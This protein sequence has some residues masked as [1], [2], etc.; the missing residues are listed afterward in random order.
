MIIII[1][2][3]ADTGL[4]KLQIFAYKE[5]PGKSG[6]LG[7]PQKANTNCQVM[8]TTRFHGSTTNKK[9]IR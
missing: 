8:C 6:K 1:V 2:T 4:S 3:V 9:C 7:I 5:K